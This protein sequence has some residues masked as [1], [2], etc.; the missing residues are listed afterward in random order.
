MD[1]IIDFK[2]IVEQAPA[3]EPARQYYFMDRVRELVEMKKQEG[4]AAHCMVEVMGCQ[5]SAKD[6]EK[7]LGI[8]ER[9]GYTVTEDDRDADVV[10]FTTCTVR[11]NA[12]MKLYGRVGRLKHQYERRDGMIIGITG[13]MMQEKDEVEGIRKRYPYV[14]LVFGTHNVYKL[15]ELLYQTLVTG[16]RT[17][18]VLEDTKLIVEELPSDRRY[19]FKGAVNIS[20]GCNNFC[21]YC[22]VP[23]V[24]GR[25]KSRN[26]TAILRECEQL[27]ADGCLEI[28]LLGQNVNS[29]GNDIPGSTSFPELLAAVAELPGLRRVRYMTSNPKDLS[30]E[31]IEVMKTHPNIE[32]HIHLPLQSGSSAILKRMNRH[33]TKESYLALVEKIRRELPEVALTTDIIVGFPGE[34]E[35]D[36]QDTVEVVQQA[37]FDAAYTFIYSKRTGTPAA[38]YEQVPEEDVKDRFARLLKIVQESSAANETRDLGKT[39]EVLVEDENKNQE[40]YLTGRLSN[41]VL[42]HFP[43]P[44]ELIGTMQMVKLTESKG[45]YYFGELVG[46]QSEAQY[47][48]TGSI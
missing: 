35:A 9:C 1:Y 45:F 29:Y 37:Q 46:R 7:L 30:D 11:E 44:K 15:A 22:I 23:Y 31:L 2:E 33:Y 6:G 43:G 25:E 17:F 36:F 38:S 47:C 26:A 39:M 19:R 34:T 24:R 41:S 40:G 21:T 13:C 18:E 28:T 10:L 12:N 48:E 20:Y 14:R 4:Y 8:L 5:M 16:K 3:E 27:I 42:V 32:R